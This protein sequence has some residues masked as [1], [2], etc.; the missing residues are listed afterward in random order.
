MVIELL[1]RSSGILIMAR[2]VERT[3]EIAIYYNN[4]NLIHEF[5]LFGAVWGRD[6]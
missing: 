6:Q 3:N 5:C 2:D 4:V 1:F